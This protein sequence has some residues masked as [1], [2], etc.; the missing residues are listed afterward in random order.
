MKK[1]VLTLLVALGFCF[2]NSIDEIKV[3]DVDSLSKAGFEIK[4]KASVD[5]LDMSK[6]CLSFH[7][8]MKENL[9]GKPKEEVRAFKNE[10]YIKTYNELA[11]LSKDDRAKFDMK[12]CSKYLKNDFNAKRNSCAHNQN[13]MGNFEGCKNNLKGCNKGF[14]CPKTGKKCQKMDQNYSCKNI[15]TA[16]KKTLI[17][18]LKSKENVGAKNC[19][20]Y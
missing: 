20:K 9:K 6:E 4:K 17:I 18:A 14:E 15:M 1:L 10:I 3:G 12:I 5:G 13:M 19:L 2:A 11:K 16:P 7:N 8:K